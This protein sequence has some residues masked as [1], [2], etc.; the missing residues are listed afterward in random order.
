[1]IKGKLDL[2]IEF[3]DMK[4][5]VYEKNISTLF[6]NRVKFKLFEFKDYEIEKVMKIKY[7]N[8]DID[9]LNADNYVELNKLIVKKLKSL[10][11]KDDN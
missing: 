7:N 5:K 11:V 9:Y 2:I 10:E 4:F 1:M 3:L 8:I 6:A